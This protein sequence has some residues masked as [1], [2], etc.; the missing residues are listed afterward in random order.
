M[1]RINKLTDKTVEI[2][3]LISVEEKFSTPK[4]VFLKYAA[5]KGVHFANGNGGITLKEKD[6]KDEEF[7]F[8]FL[9]LCTCAGQPKR[10]RTTR[11]QLFFKKWK[12]RTE[13]FSCP[14]EFSRKIPTAR[15]DV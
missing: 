15:L 4:W 13:R 7:I 14:K 3:A 10:A 6:L 11:L 12:L 1:S 9:E 5:I 8:N 2:Q